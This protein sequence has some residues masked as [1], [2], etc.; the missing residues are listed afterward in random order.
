MFGKKKKNQNDISAEE[1]LEQLKANIEFD[2]IE[3][4]ADIEKPDTK[5]AAKL[6][7]EEVFG[8]TEE[9][10]VITEEVTGAKEE[11]EEE[12]TE[13]AAE[14]EKPSS[15]PEENEAPEAADEVKE[16]EM[17]DTK[18]NEVVSTKEFSAVDTPVPTAEYDTAE[19]DL[20]PEEKLSDSEVDALM[21]KYLSDA[22]YEEVLRTR[23]DS[24]DED[25]AAHISEAEEYVSSIESEIEKDGPAEPATATQK[26]IS[27]LDLS[28]AGGADEQFDETDVNLMI[29][30]GMQDELEEKL[31]DESAQMVKEALDKDAQTFAQAKRKDETPAEIDRNM[32]FESSSQIKE[33]FNIYKK[34]YRNILIRFYCSLAA[35]V[36]VF[37]FENFTALGG[38][39]PTWLDPQVFPVIAS[40]VSLQLLL[41]ACIPVIKPVLR[42]FGSLFKG[43]PTSGSL[44]SVALLLSVCYHIAICFVYRGGEMVF[45]NVP[46]VL[47]IIFTV[48]SE[49]FTL[50][51]DI[52]TF[53][54]ISSKRVKHVIAKMPEDQAELEHEIFDEY[55]DEDSSIFRVSKASFVDGFFRRTREYSGN[56]SVLGIIIAIS[57]VISAFFLVFTGFMQHD[58][59]LAVRNAYIALLITTPV[60]AFVTFSYP[61]Y[62]AAKVSFENG[63]AIV[64]ESSLEEYSNAGAISFD[65]RDVFPSNKVKVTGIKIY[66]NNRIDRVIFNVASLFKVLGGPLCDVFNIATKEFECSD[67]VEIVDISAD[68]IEAVISGKHIF[69][70]KASYLH[71]N[72]FEPVYERDDEKIEFSGEASISYLVCNDEVAAKI[73]VHYSMDPDFVSI[74][75]QL[76]NAG[77]CIGIKSF[78]PNID[79]TL[80][81]KHI[82]LSKYAVKILK[83]HHTSEK[84]VTEE[85]SDSGIVSKKNP[86][87]LLKTLALCDRV[88]SVTRTSLLIKA[89]SILL[90]FALTLFAVIKGQTSSDFA[91]LYIAGYQIFWLIPVWII[92]L[93]N[94]KK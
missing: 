54:I 86:K 40:M 84:T 7:T 61:M 45:C 44:L 19:L 2:S 31:G 50:K 6:P 63:S 73:Y 1:L 58:W 69:Y 17:G 82:N 55:I 78:D 47:C 76:H 62:R 27:E 68:G 10:D 21:K 67:D 75:K 8:E 72:N 70:G 89:L 92:T 93:F 43:K 56:K 49:L 85:R 81:A 71:K 88:N 57:L 91:G 22:E 80:L 11:E 94:I 83:C 4:P 20:T 29:A 12:V 46:L 79:D 77:M 59:A 38:K 5:P 33:V 24:I 64:G 41:L 66:G 35:L 65:D 52:F 53:N 60:S 74:T 90:A 14:T 51:R 3:L 26:V 30:F 87:S 39:F 23:N 28:S 37:I 18:E 42:G 32:E 48:L 13:K 34:Q 25:F 15:E 16:D 36:A 9:M